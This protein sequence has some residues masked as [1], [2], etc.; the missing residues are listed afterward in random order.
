MVDLG[1][2]PFTQ[3]IQHEVACLENVFFDSK[4]KSIVWRTEKTLK[5]GT[6]PEVTIVTKKTIV[7]NIKEDPERLALMGIATAHANAYNVSKLKG[8]MDQYKD[9]MAQMKETLRKER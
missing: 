9:K 8:A 1:L 5:M 7:G 4:R 6:Q 2:V 3:S